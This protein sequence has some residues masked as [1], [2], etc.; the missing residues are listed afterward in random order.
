MLNWIFDLFKR[1]PVLLKPATVPTLKHFGEIIVPSGKYRVTLPALTGDELR[2]YSTA[3]TRQ[4][5]VYLNGVLTRSEKGELDADVVVDFIAPYESEG[6]IQI[7]HFDRA[8]NPAPGELF[9]FVATDTVPP[10]AP[11]YG[12]LLA[13]LEEI[14]DEPE[15]TTSSEEETTSSSAPEEEEEEVTTSSEDTTTS[16]FI[17]EEEEEATTSSEEATSS[18]APDEDT[19]SSSGV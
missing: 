14:A 18:S 11:S 12:F 6:A 1:R 15:T 13:Q 10:V 8:K 16:S 2:K 9:T 5:D 4:L 7:I 3:S 17:P 19:S